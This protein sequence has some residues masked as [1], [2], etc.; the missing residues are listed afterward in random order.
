MER[1]SVHS[2]NLRTYLNDDGGIF[3]KIRVFCQALIIDSAHSVLAFGPETIKVYVVE[4]DTRVRKHIVTT[5]IANDGGGI[6]SSNVK[7]EW[8]QPEVIKLCLT[9]VEQEDSVL[10]INLRTFSHIAGK[11]NCS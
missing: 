7:A 9:G 3:G 2:E 1:P 4:K 8:M 5:K 6:S 11:E 10:K